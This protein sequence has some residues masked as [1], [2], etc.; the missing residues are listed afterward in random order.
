MQRKREGKTVR[1]RLRM[2]VQA[3]MACMLALSSAALPTQVH[4]A[5]ETQ[6]VSDISIGGLRDVKNLERGAQ[7][8]VFISTYPEEGAELSAR[9]DDESIAKISLEGNALQIQGV[10]EGTCEVTV[11][12]MMNGKIEQESFSVQVIAPLYEESAHEEVNINESDWRFRLEQDMSAVPAEHTVPVVDDSWDHVQVP[13]CWNS[14]DGADGGNDYIRGKG[15]YI[16]DI[17]LSDARY[18]DKD[19]YLE[20][21][22]ACK[23]TDVYVNGEYVG[24]HEGGWSSAPT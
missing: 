2:L 21:Q 12:A 7:T 24:T 3:S 14:E 18:Q 10:A 16:T 23:I 1:K 6:I 8:Y 15:W 19:L 4:A 9:C 20:V 17:D 22:G 11:T 13:H 5:S